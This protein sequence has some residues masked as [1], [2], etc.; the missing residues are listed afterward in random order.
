MASVE[1]RLYF[2]NQP[3]TREQL[4]QVEVI[5][6]EQELD[7]AWHAQL[8]I[9]ICTDDKGNWKDQAQQTFTTDFSRV[10]VEVKVGKAGFVALIDGPIV[11]SSRQQS[12]QPGQSMITVMVQDDSYYLHRADT[13]ARFEKKL[14]HEIAQTL[15]DVAKQQIKRQKIETTPSPTSTPTPDV[16]QRGT[17]MELLRSLARRQGKHAYVLPGSEPGQS[18]G[19]FQ[20]FPQDPDGLPSLILVGSDRNL[21]EFHPTYSA[22]Q[23]AKFQASTLSLTDKTIATQTSDL[24]DVPRV[25]A[26]PTFQK[27]ANVPLQIVRPHHGDHVNLTQLV[28][29]HAREASYT[30]TATG[31]VLSD[32]YTG[33]L[34]P[35]RVV[36]VYGID[37]R[38]SG[39][40]EITKVTHTLNRANYS[41]AFT[42]RRNGRSPDPSASANN[43]GGL[44]LASA[45][46][47][48]SFNVQ[49]SIF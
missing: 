25:G 46:F 4:D 48:I 28:N 32:C 18:I 23:A 44:P 36:G 19:C 24:N 37:A 43:N 9:P 7:M 39:T 42:L 14:D 8:Q 15:F 2:A 38:A 6:V 49:G 33:V 22:Q 1:Y 17:E 10:R 41:Q 26:E 29:A 13:I 45:S 27:E 11:G 30:V 31:S 5:T 20:A 12:S 21:A 47:A 40:Y 16:M 3:A 34:S 35:Y